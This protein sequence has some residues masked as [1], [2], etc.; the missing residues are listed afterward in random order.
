MRFDIVDDKLYYRTVY[1]MSL[2]EEIL[3]II[4]MRDIESV[5]LDM[6]VGDKLYADLVAVGKKGATED[7]YFKLG[8]TQIIRDHVLQSE[9]PEPGQQYFNFEE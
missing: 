3:K 2:D 5:E 7:D 8:F 4:K 9:D 6:E 1:V